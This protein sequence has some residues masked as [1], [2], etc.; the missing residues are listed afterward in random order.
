MSR[1]EVPDHATAH[2]ITVRW[3][4]MDAYGHVNN[5]QYLRFLEE[6]RIRAFRDWFAAVDA[7]L[8][9]TGILVVSQAIDYLLPMEFTYEPAR[10]RVWCSEIGSSSFELGYAVQG[11]EGDDTV[12]AVARVGLVTYD[13]AAR[14]PRRLDAGERSVLEAHRGPAPT[15][16]S[17]RRAARRAGETR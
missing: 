6:A 3:S 8:L 2:P 4:D 14:R 13:L 1:P 17:E 16:R 9:G 5:V 7:D 12:F 10:V 15:L 11:P